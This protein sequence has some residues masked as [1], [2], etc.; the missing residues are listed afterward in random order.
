VFLFPPLRDAGMVAP[1]FVMLR[2]H[3]Q[4]WRAGTSMPTDL[5]G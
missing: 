2:E 4:M 3:G 1:V 5:A